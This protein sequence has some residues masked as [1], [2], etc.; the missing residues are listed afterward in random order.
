MARKDDTKKKIMHV[1]LKLFSEQGYYQ[2]T[3]K[4]VAQEAGINEVTLFR[5]FGTKE[6]LFQETTQ[7]YVI[8]INFSR[9]FKK[10]ITADFKETIEKLALLY[11]DYCRQNT[12]L[13]KIQMRLSDETK[14]FTKLK[15]SIEFKKYL[16]LYF[17][18]LAG[19]KII[20]GDASIMADSLIGAWLGSF[21]VYLLSAGTFS[22][23]DLDAIVLEQARQFSSHYEKR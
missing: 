18:T 11:L 12:K 20:S 15:L 6:N 7:E 17:K 13:Y 22:D 9:E 8:E 1:A 5:H 23:N 14:S 4:Q 16:V 10:I 21:T 19:T 3:T 2:T